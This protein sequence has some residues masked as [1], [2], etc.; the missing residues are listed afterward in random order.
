MGA[1]LP[2]APSGGIVEPTEDLSSNSRTIAAERQ[3]ADAL[4]EQLHAAKLAT[5]EAL[6]AAAQARWQAAEAQ[7]LIAFPSIQADEPQ[8]MG[9]LRHLCQCAVEITEAT[10][11]KDRSP[12]RSRRPWKVPHPKA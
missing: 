8:A 3:R 7:E 4:H 9:R 2:V 1:S 12:T 10:S 5:R 6:E 11:S